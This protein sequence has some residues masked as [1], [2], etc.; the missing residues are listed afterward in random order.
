MFSINS[1]IAR[2]AKSIK[3]SCPFPEAFELGE[4]KSF[5][6]GE[7]KKEE[8][9][10]VCAKNEPTESTVNEFY[11]PQCGEQTDSID[12]LDV[13]Q[14]DLENQYGYRVFYWARKIDLESCSYYGDSPNPK[15]EDPIEINVMFSQQGENPLYTQFGR[16][17]DVDVSF[18]VTISQWEEKFG[19]RP[20]T[21][22][23]RFLLPDE[24][25][26][27]P[28]LQDP[29]VYVVLNKTDL[30]S[31]GFVGPYNSVYTWKVNAKRSTNS[32]E[33]NAPEEDFDLPAIVN[34][35]TFEPSDF[36]SDQTEVIEEIVDVDTI[37]K[38]NHPSMKRKVPKRR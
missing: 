24:N 13:I 16:F 2:K 9:F 22:G 11:N 25:C 5:K 3:P 31:N 8:T 36:L 18:T 28:E 12:A 6:G 35:E 4:Q 21:E 7:T 33:E 38:K 30:E 37:M 14:R 29:R 15:F 23:D 34:P 17:S 32:F 20:P 27:R 1:L 26:A 10:D 19:N